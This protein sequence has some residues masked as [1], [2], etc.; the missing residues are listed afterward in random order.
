VNEEATDEPADESAKDTTS[1]P[2]GCCANVRVAITRTADH[3]NSS[4]NDKAYCAPGQP[5]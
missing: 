3:S 2:E 5:V 1:D 4:P